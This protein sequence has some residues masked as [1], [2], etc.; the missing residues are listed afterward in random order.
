MADKDSINPDARSREDEYF[1]RK[2]RELI[3]KMR[4]AAAADQ[5]RAQLGERS[6]LRDPALVQELEALGFTPDTVILLPLVPIVQVAWAEGGVTAQERSLIVQLARQRGVEAGSAADLQLE[7]WLKEQPSEDVFARATR[8]IRAMLDDPAQEH[9]GVRLDDLI[10]HC[11]AIASASG[12]V[13]GFRK[14]SPEEQAL[15]AQI[16]AALKGK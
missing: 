15:L 13:L 16:E 11:E 1:R 7:T 12:G 14:I 2:D 3:E 6:G 5:A 8:L 4:Q 9:A 10:H